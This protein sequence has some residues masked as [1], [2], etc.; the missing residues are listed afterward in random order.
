MN[1]FKRGEIM[2][3]NIM[4]QTEKIMC[5]LTVMVITAGSV[6]SANFDREPGYVYPKLS[7]TG[8]PEQFKPRQYVIYKA[9]DQIT[10]DG[11]LDETSWASAEWTNQFA[12]ILSTRGYTKSFLAT[13]AKMLWDDEKLYFAA[14]ME[15][16]NLIGY[17]TKNDT[18]VCYESDFEIFIDIDCDAQD[19]IELQ[20]NT[21]GTIFDIF[22]PKE[23]HRGG[24]P[25]GWPQAFYNTKDSP[26]WDLEGMLIAVRVDGSLNYPLDTDKGWTLEVSIPWE[27]LQKTSRTGNKLNRNGT[28][29]RVGMSRVEFNWPKDIWPIMD[30]NKKGS[31]WD[32]TW[33]PNLAYDMHVPETWGRVILSERTVHRSKDMTLENSFPFVDPPRSRKKP[34]TGNMVKIKGGTYTIGPDRT[35]PEPSPK[36]EIT[37]KDFYIDRYE[38]TIGEYAKFL[39]AGNHDKHYMDDMADPHLCG[40][41]KKGEGRYE[42]VPGKEYYPM[43]FMHPESAEACAEW[44]GKRLPT[45]FEW[46]IAARGSAGRLY[47][48]G[49]E[50]PDTNRANFNFLIGHTTPVGSFDKGKTP[51]GLHDMAGNVWELCDGLWNE[52]PWGTKLVGRTKGRRI[53]RGGS[54]VT[55]AGNIA[56]TYRNAMKYSGWAGMIGFRCA[57]DAD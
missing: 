7:E 17:I 21:L 40:I 54:W 18:V 48:W 24:L 32:W 5:F 31:N 39:N 44:M 33:T 19:Y 22:Y 2:K 29:F 41:V 47:P 12:H 10:I 8:I 6:F 56:S 55:S 50:P 53:M 37:V 51:E 34:K 52:Y 1:A 11:A 20:F 9:V 28:V 43:V 36:G 38:V 35:D 30:W 13:R 23:F 49:N 45:E 16:P 25:H 46:E 14:V 42:V 3:I 4:Q 26:E 27:S 15:E 57:K